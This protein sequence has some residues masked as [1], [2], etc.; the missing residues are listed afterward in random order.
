MGH[1][2]GDPTIQ[3]RFDK[4]GGQQYGQRNQYGGYQQGGAYGRGGRARGGMRSF[5]SP[6]Q[7]QRSRT[8]ATG[9]KPE[10]EAESS[11]GS[12]SS[13]DEEGDESSSNHSDDD[14]TTFQCRERCKDLGMVFKA[15][16]ILA[17]EKKFR[18]F[19]T[20]LVQTIYAFEGKDAPIINT[21]FYDS[22]RKCL[23]E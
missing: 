1:S 11:S 16:M 13:E 10:P 8:Q 19:V 22:F 4:R 6:Q 7:A 20:N 21:E 9:R 14:E 3:N 23:I 18:W 17:N 15:D 2:K 12:E 5:G